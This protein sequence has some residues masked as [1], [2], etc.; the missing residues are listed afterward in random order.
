MKRENSGSY[1]RMDFASQ[2]MLDIASKPHQPQ[3]GSGTCSGFPGP[4]RESEVGSDLP[5]P[6]GFIPLACISFFLFSLNLFLLLFPPFLLPAPHTTFCLFL[7]L[8]AFLICSFY[9][10]GISGPH[11]KKKSCLGP[12]IKYTTLTK[13]DK[14]KK[15]EF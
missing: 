7:P 8:F 1:C 4:G 13:T 14:Q 11:W 3:R 5:V 15:K 12:H 6:T 9:P 2:K 10:F